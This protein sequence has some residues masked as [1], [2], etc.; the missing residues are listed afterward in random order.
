[1]GRSILNDEIMAKRSAL[2]SLEDILKSIELLERYT[3]SIS[4]DEF[5][6][7]FEKQDAVVRRIGIIGE[8]TKNLPDTMRE[9]YSE[10]QWKSSTGLLDDYF[11][12]RMSEIWQV[13]TVE[14]PSLKPKIQQIIA[15]LEHK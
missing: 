6:V 9:Q 14:L 8:A 13:A 2:L 15:D 12:L 11:G 7:N 1:M 4:F 10:V 5:D 3:S